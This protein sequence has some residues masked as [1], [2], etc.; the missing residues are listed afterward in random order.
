MNHTSNIDAILMVVGTYE[1]K[2]YLAKKELFKPCI[3]GAFLKTLGAIKIDRDSA[4]LGAIKQALGVLKQNKKLVIFP[5]G[6]RSMSDDMQMRE[7]KNGAAMLA[8]KSKSPIVPVWIFSR[9]KA[10]KMTKVLI[11][12]PY[13]L[14]EF[15]GQR[16]SEEVLNEASEIILQKLNELKSE[17]E[18]KFKRKNK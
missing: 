1:K 9:P 7:V 14:D 18:E 3:K 4:D 13:E 8:I 5:E 15:Y 2:Y 12:K 16:L 6:T 17:A 10:F 11:G